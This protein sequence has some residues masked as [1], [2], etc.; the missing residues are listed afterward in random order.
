[1]TGHVFYHLPGTPVDRCSGCG[2]GPGDPVHLMIFDGMGDAVEAQEQAAAKYQGE[3]LTA[4]MLE[5]LG[6]INAKAARMEEDAPLFF[7]K[8][9]ATLF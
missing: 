5:P 2:R 7:G 3:E 1:M 4:E 9:N 6:N 8:V